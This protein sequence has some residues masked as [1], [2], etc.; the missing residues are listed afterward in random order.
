MAMTQQQKH[1]ILAVALY[2]PTVFVLTHI[3]TPEVV[4]NARVSDKS[5]H[6]LVYMILTFLLW[7]AFGPTEKANWRRA[8]TWGLLLVAVVY[9][10]GDE[11]TQ[12]FVAGRSPDRDDLLAD[13]VGAS[14]GL[15]VAAIFSF[16]PGCVLVAGTTIYT[17]AVFTRANLTR[18]VPVTSTVLSF[19]SYG[20][21]TLLW[22]GYMANGTGWK[23]TGGRWLAASLGAPGAL[24]VVTKI[25]TLV[26]GKEFEGWDILS[27]VVGILFVV[28][29]VSIARRV[30]PKNATGVEVSAAEA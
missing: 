16:W 21:F 27:A 17:L 13:V 3:P 22:I 19:T 26:S 20:I 1:R 12:R 28:A 18:L 15:V 7:S 29:A 24:L 2:W 6:V 8:V 23:K 9:A 10:L 30:W 25:S 4:R 11:Y 5:L 14:A